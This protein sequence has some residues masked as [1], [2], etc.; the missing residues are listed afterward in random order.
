VTSGKYDE[1]A[2]RFT[3]HEYGDPAAYFAH[4]AAIVVALGPRLEPGDTVLD[5]ACADGSF[6]PAL[7]AHGLVYRGVDASAPMVEAARARGL[8]AEQGDLATYRPAAPVAATAIFRS[9]HLVPDRP[10]FFAHVAEFTERKLV[11]DFNPRRYAPAL[12]RDELHRAGLPHVELHP[13]FVP[14]HAA[15]PRP[16]AAA[17]RALERSGPLARLVLAVRFS[18]LC[19]ASRGS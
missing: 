9:L 18:Y 10:V 16:A 6:G 8:D 4:R 17:L 14:Q 19:A 15:L 3:E 12:L 1:L 5:L 11:F 7:A 13:F 2:G